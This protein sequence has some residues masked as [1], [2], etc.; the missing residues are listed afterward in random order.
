MRAVPA[1]V[2]TASCQ[3]AERNGNAASVSASSGRINLRFIFPEPRLGR[4]VR[5]ETRR[6]LSDPITTRI[7]IINA[8]GTTDDHPG[9]LNVTIYLRFRDAN[10]ECADKGKED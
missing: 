6:V 5:G 7:K 8:N 1:V 3:S 9:V 2:I 10:D 4:L